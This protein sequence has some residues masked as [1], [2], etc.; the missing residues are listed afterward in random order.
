ME[1]KK[2]V[3]TKINIRL[4][5]FFYLFIYA[6]LVIRE[7]LDTT[8][9]Y[10]PWPPKIMYIFYLL[11][12]VYVFAKMIWGK[13]FTWK[14]RMFSVLI[15]AVFTASAWV[16][17]YYFLFVLGLLI[18]GAKDVPVD[19][20]LK[21]YFVI[22]AV[23]MVTA[24]AASQVGL[25]ENYVYVVEGKG[26]RNSFGINYTTDFAAHIFYLIL[27]GVCI[28]EHKAGI[29]GIV[30]P[31]IGAVLVYAGS[32]AYTS[33]IC[34]ILFAVSVI[35]VKLCDVK[36]QEPK[37]WINILPWAPAG[38]AGIFIVLTL[39]YTPEH[40]IWDKLNNIL[41]SRLEL[42]AR[43]IDQNGIKPFGQM[44]D[45]IGMGGHTEFPMGYFFLDDS[46]IRILLEYGI[47][48]FAFI[49]VMLVLVGKKAIANKR[50][51]LLMACF[52]ISL[53]SVMEHHLLEIAYNPFILFLF[54]EMG[55]LSKEERIPT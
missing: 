28:H 36:Y 52:I 49:L 39:L 6:G 32:R 7:F 45:E 20:I 12:L 43:G 48:V 51:I 35:I 1:E 16:S 33:C 44:I 18:V 31:L 40:G 19:Q 2:A 34:L 46:Y 54:A 21:I 9:I 27:A 30:F 4:W 55:K 38:F 14:E 15:I 37:R 8:T 29:R 23:I 53:Q 13:C 11:L 22:A 41:N 10:I 47:F 42:S 26:V 50:F 24:F 5:D 25:I 17:G 3:R